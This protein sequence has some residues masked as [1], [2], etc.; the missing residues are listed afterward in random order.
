MK[1]CMLSNAESV[2]A[3]R[4]AKAF[5]ERGHEVH[6]LSI[7]KAD[8]FGVNVHTVRLGP[9]NSSSVFWKFLS[10]LYFLAS[11]RRLIRKLNPDIVNAH[12]VTT[13]GVIAAFA[14]YHP[15]VISLWGTG[16][17]A[18][19]GTHLPLMWRLP[20][21]YALKRAD[22]VCS[23]SKYMVDE[24]LKVVKPAAPIVQ[25]P[26]GINCDLFSPPDE[27]RRSEYSGEFRIGF[28]KTL[29][30]MY[31]PDFLMDAMP[32]ICSQIPNAKLILVGRGNMRGKLE[33]QASR[34]GI[35]DK[36]EFTGFIPNEKLPETMRTFDVF[37]NPTVVNESFGVVILEAEACGVPV[38]ATNVGGVPEVCIDG[39]TG[40][41]VPPRDAQ[42][43]AEKIILLAKDTELRRKM[44]IEARKFVLQNYRWE[45]NVDKML[46]LFEEQI[47]IARSKVK[48]K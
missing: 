8:I 13:H 31:G 28:V 30:P 41:L 33:K 1:I 27:T 36:V 19:G 44:S 40:F 38:A 15:L 45:D 34:L 3:Q 23:T 26:F 18:S 10:Y 37:V 25:V 39:K 47:R 7:R 24:T 22:L 14:G 16:V 46:G 29:L 17:V 20:P 5:A 43:I 9:V 32:I 12:Y 6:L 48:S 11:A 35:S 2:H 42:A 21:F 4:W